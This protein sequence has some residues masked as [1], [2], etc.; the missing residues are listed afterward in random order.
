MAEE[1]LRDAIK[2]PDADSRIKQNLI[3]VLGVQ[4]KF[5]ADNIPMIAVMFLLLAT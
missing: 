1:T 5:G 2:L 3:M 4:G